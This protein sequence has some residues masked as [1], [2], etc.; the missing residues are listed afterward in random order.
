[1]P[2]SQ[3]ME[4]GSRSGGG[5][6]GGG[7]DLAEEA[8]GGPGGEA[9]GGLTRNSGRELAAYLAFGRPEAWAKALIAPACFVMAA[10]STGRLGDWKRFAVLWLVL[11]FLIY[12]ARYQW[13]DIRGVDADLRHAERA[14]RSRLPVGTTAGAR[15]RSI[16]LSRLTAAAR[17]LAALLVGVLVG[18][19]RQ[20]LLLAVAVFAVAAAYEFLRALGPGAPRGARVAAVWVVVGFGYVVRGA[21][22]LSTAGLAWGSL[23]MVAGLVCVGSFGIMFVLLTWALEATSYCA[24]DAGGGW[25]ARADLVA[26]PHLAALLPYLGRPVQ[27]SGG[28]ETGGE[29]GAGGRAV[30]GAVGPGRYCGTDR[31]LRRGGRLSAPWNLALLAATVSG[32][33]EGVALARPYGGGAGAFLAAVAVSV[34]GAVLLAGCRSSPGRWVITAACAPVL[35]AAALL[36]GAALPALAAAPWLA[37]AGL[38]SAFR[39]WSYRDLVAAGPR[40]TAAMRRARGAVPSG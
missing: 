25:H 6:A 22:G 23:A 2:S 15:R 5:P 37:I 26:K 38:Y 28:A 7:G 9:A 27:A 31:V 39:D 30:G 36:A 35:A 11:E 19:T 32:A 17:I 40:L 8:A 14:A 4:P 12:A 1:M 29:I 21:L 16:R 18:L 24:A 10:T 13:N 3:P 20:V 34:A 33:V